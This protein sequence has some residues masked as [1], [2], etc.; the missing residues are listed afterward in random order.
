M[1]RARRTAAKARAKLSLT[2]K[3][4]ESGKK[5]KSPKI[6]TLLKKKLL[7][8]DDSADAVG[9]ATEKYEK[10]KYAQKQ[11][12]EE[13]I[14]A[15]EAKAATMNARLRSDAE[16]QLKNIDTFHA[17]RKEHSLIEAVRRL[18]GW[19]PKQEEEHFEY[20]AML[21]DSDEILDTFEA[22][23]VEAFAAV[24]QIIP[25]D[26]I[27]HARGME[28]VSDAVDFLKNLFDARLKAGMIT[29]AQIDGFIA[30]FPGSDELKKYFKENDKDLIIGLQ[31]D[32]SE[33]KNRT[34]QEQ[35]LFERIAK[36]EKEGE[37]LDA[38]SSQIK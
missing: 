23:S 28:S 14:S 6:R 8:V 34:D 12:I 36:W 33:K 20:Q 13:K 22:K 26:D 3:E 17:V 38:I 2:E 15:R 1:E 27:D 21:S 4:I 7:T 32:L 5:R 19:G 9:S 16:S 37:L 29:E 18:F 31:H 25:K 24:E 10:E 30:Q 35:R 11:R